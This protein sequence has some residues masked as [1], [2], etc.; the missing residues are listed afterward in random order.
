MRFAGWPA[1]YTAGKYLRQEIDGDVTEIPL[2]D[3]DRLEVERYSWGLTLL[4]FPLTLI[5]GTV[6]FLVHNLRF[7]FDEVDTR[8]DTFSRPPGGHTDVGEIEGPA[9][10]PATPPPPPRSR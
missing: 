1:V 7:G 9:P 2:A 8:F 3:V 6:D 5:P 10:Q 4:S